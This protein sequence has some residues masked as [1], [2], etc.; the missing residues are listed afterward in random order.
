MDPQRVDELEK[1]LDDLRQRDPRADLKPALRSALQ[2]ARDDDETAFILSRIAGELQLELAKAPSD[3]TH[4]A[5]FDEVE[6][7]LRRCVELQPNDPYYR[8]RLAEHFHYY[9][10]DLKKALEAVNAAVEKAETN[11]MFVRQAHG[12]RIRIALDLKD[13]L[14]VEKSLE[15]LS[16]YSPSPGSP[17]VAPEKDFLKR[18]PPGAVPDDLVARYKA[19]L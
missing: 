1:R 19:I 12:T 11:R 15:V 2:A 16:S 13:Y 7:L 17:D 4:K 18:L 6:A 10:S 14:T 3:R 5:R 9:A 8:I